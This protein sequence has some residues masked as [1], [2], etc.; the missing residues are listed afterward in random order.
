MNKKEMELYTNK[1]PIGGLCL[2]NWGGLEVLD[3][4]SE[5][6]VYRFNYGGEPEQPRRARLY[7]GVKDTSFRSGRSTY[8]LSDIM[9]F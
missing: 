2:S 7:Y 1:Q 6:I 8:H 3:I 4:N 9:R 5:Y